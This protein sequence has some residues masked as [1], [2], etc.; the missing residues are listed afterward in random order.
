MQRIPLPPSDGTSLT[1]HIAPARKALEHGE[2]VVVPTDTVYGLAAQ[3]SNRH[4]CERMY[5]AKG[6][7][8]DQATAVLFASVRQ[9][10]WH[11]PGLSERARIAIETLLP[12]PYTLIVH[13]ADLVTPWLCGINPEAIG[14][15][16]PHDALPLPP[17]A[18]TSANVAGQAEASEIDAIPAAL[19]ARVGVAIDAGRAIGTSST[20]L[21]L[22]AWEDGG[23]V[24]VLRD[25]GSRADA[26][27]G[28]LSDACD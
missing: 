7:K 17:L 20:V 18:A 3:A 6:R 8:T 19:A 4:A 15:R 24:V 10:V 16:V 12:G 14:V 11:M 1:R 9:V 28:M 27:I 23:A 13:N 21:D 25:I 5:R 22:T 26:A 2:M